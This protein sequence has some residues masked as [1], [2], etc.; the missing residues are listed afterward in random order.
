MRMRNAL[1]APLL[2]ALALLAPGA[3]GDETSPSGGTI[4]YVRYPM[5]KEGRVVPSSLVV[6]ARDGAEIAAFERFP[7]HR[8]YGMRPLSADAIVA[9]HPS[10]V[11]AFSTAGKALWEMS[12]A[13]L[14]GARIR[15]VVG[16]DA[17]PNGNLLVGAAL[18]EAGDA[19]AAWAAMEIDREGKV[20][21]TATLQEPIGGIRAL[22]GEAGKERFLVF[23]GGRISETDWAGS[24]LSSVDL[25]PKAQILDVDRTPEGNLLFA[26][27]VDHR[28]TAA[29]IDP[30]GRIVRS[31]PHACP[32]AVQALPDGHVLLRGG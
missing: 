29:E 19:E 30:S 2:G 18:G 5:R 20:V 28:K 21:R 24:A 3:Q 7:K 9:W 8:P 26:G 14:Q 27:V 1:L 32:I 15:C 12:A 22:R 10:G 17:L 25:G 13:D 4:A 31:F 6:C 16:A 11:L 23:R